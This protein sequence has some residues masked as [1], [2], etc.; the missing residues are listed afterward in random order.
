MTATAT[1]YDGVHFQV[2]TMNMRDGSVQ[3]HR[4]G[5]ADL[6]RGTSKFAEPSQANDI[7]DVTSLHEAWVDYNADFLGECDTHEESCNEAHDA[8]VNA[9]DIQWLPCVAGIPATVEEAEKAVS[10]KAPAKAKAKKAKSA[11]APAKPVVTVR[12]TGKYVRV[13]LGDKE[14]GYLPSNLATVAELEKLFGL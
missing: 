6:K 8:C 2:V 5:C 4:A 3:G 9:Y 11:K 10:A 13:Y 1:K 7:L 14:V 12:S